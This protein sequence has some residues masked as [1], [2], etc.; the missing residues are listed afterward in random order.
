MCL[1]ILSPLLHERD[2]YM[3]WSCKRSRA[4]CGARAVVGVV[5]RAH[6]RGTA[7]HLLQVRKRMHRCKVSELLSGNQAL[8]C[9]A[10]WG[11]PTSG[12]VAWRC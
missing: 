12:S 8:T 1:Q 3:A 6:L 7:Y 5:G 2:S 4:V 11:C 10:P 9:S